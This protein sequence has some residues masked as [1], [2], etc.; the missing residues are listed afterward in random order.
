MRTKQ[1]KGRV[2][3]M[4]K[5]T[6]SLFFLP[7]LMG[8]AALLGGCDSK[9]DVRVLRVLNC[10]DYIYEY[11]EQEDK[12]YQVEGKN[13][14][15]EDVMDQ[16]VDYWAETHDGEEI[17]YVY[18]TFDTNETMFNELKTGKTSYDV[19]VPSDYMIQKL[20]SNDMLHKISSENKDALWANISGYLKNEF[21]SIKAVY[22]NEDKT[23]HQEYALSEFSVPYMWGTVGLM[24]NPSYYTENSDLTEEEVHKL[25]EDWDS[26]YTNDAIKGTYSIK[27]SVR[28]T[29]AVSL[30]HAYRDEIANLTEENLENGVLGEI[31][32]RHAPE[33]MAVVKEDMLKL[34][35]AAFGFECDS[36]KTDMVDQKV[37][38]NMCWS[39]D[40]TWAIEEARSDD[41]SQ[42]LD[43]YYSIPTSY[44]GVECKGASNI[45]FD[46]LCMPKNTDHEDN[47]TEDEKAQYNLAEEF[48]KFMSMPEIAA[49][50]C[51][52]VGYTPGVAGDAM[53]DYM[54]DSY[55]I[56]EDLPESPVLGEDYVEY[57]LTYFFDYE[58]YKNGVSTVVFKADP[59]TAKREL[60]AQYPEQSILNRLAVMKDFGTED[61]ARLLDMWEQV[62]TN[63]LPLWGIIVLAVEGAAVIAFVSYTIVK[64]SQRK[65]DKK[66]RS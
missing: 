62:R 22:E 1:K 51:Y 14:Y 46:G 48:I 29:Y 3:Q 12:E 21:D 7:L 64:K 5:L 50:N 9:S 42:N 63:A 41:E 18:D 17:D 38:A 27:D 37:G 53:L 54:F 20:I 57:D 26:L 39:G 10:E 43:L 34:K 8:S 60:A 65:K 56:S 23:I 2:E 32:N 13:W 30:I 31:F 44:N 35:E 47:L 15:T 19:I 25:F 59:D 55:D 11:D 45:W 28:D 36:G 40:A 6:K 61:N 4:R 33:E 24:Y 66:N 52:C 49:Q 58:S 16:F